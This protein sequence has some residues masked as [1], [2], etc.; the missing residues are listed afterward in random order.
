MIHD[1]TQFITEFVWS[2]ASYNYSQDKSWSKPRFDTVLVRY[3][4]QVEGS[5][6]WRNEMANRRIARVHLLFS[7]QSDPDL[8]TR[9]DLAFV[10]LFRTI[11]PPDPC[12]G[13][14]KVIK[15]RFE[16]IEI[17]TIE[18]GV[19]LIPCFKGLETEM[20]S[21]TSPPSLDEYRE[22]W[23]NNHTDMHIFNSVY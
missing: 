1:R 9:I 19:H 12:S 17:G 2:T 13:M 14:F 6:Q 7:I 4:A 8:Q 21:S 5:T 22:F 11:Q 23:V 16:V 18:R 15:D 3:E 20:A 10:Q